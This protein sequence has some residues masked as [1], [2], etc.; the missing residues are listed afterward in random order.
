MTAE[1]MSSGLFEPFEVRAPAKLNLMLRVLGRRPDG[2]HALQTLF[3]LLDW[4]DSLRFA[5]LPGATQSDTKTTPQQ[6]PIEIKGDFAD[7]PTEKNLIWQAAHSLL[8]F[9]K[10]PVPVSIQVS[11]RIPAGGGLGGGSSNAAS[12]LLALNR[13]WDC[14]LDADRLQA[15]GLS[16]G[17]DVPVFIA[18]RPALATGVGERLAPVALPVRHF[19][20][21]LPQE[22]IST[23]EVFADPSLPRD[24]QALPLAKALDPQ[25]WSN[26]CLA[27]AL[28]RSPSLAT[29]WQWVETVRQRLASS[30]LS[31]ASGPHLSGTGST[32]FLAFEALQTA[33]DFLHALE[34]SRQALASLGQSVPARLRLVSSWRGQSG[35]NP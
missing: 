24:S 4:G 12:T 11:K 1:G 8:R 21:I 31:G 10:K 16:L 20:L 5:P 28:T 18:R 29:S 6:P 23:A 9:A 35:E 34:Q 25:H 2:Y 7:L 19:V 17:A 33:Q 14:A 32:F 30:G 22:G 15:L 27:V 13:L 3:E 26:D